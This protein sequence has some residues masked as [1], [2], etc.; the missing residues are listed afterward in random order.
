MAL[1]LRYYTQS[2]PMV[3]NNFNP[4]FGLSWVLPIE[5][6]PGPCTHTR[7]SFPGGLRLTHTPSCWPVDGDDRISYLVYSPICPGTFDSHTCNA[8]TGAT[9][10][11]SLRTVEAHMPNS[12]YS[13]ENLGFSHSFRKGWTV[14]GDVDIQQMWH[15]TRTENINSPTT[16]QPLGPR[17]FQQNIN[18]LQ[19]QATGRG[20]GNIV[21]LGVANQQYKY[22][23]FS[24][25]SVRQGFVDNTDG[26]PFTS[27]Q[28]TGSNVGEYAPRTGNALWSVFGGATEKLP[29]GLLLSENLNAQEGRRFNVTTGLDNNG[30]GNFNDRPYC[31]KLEWRSVR[32]RLQNTVP[33][34]PLMACC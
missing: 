6:P 10:L 12:F 19:W 2:K 15:L 25:S 23:Q 28:T 26:D 22:I 14:S 29:W 11:Q 3:H 32:L 13:I 33:I 5:T 34:G 24:A 4:R 16:L 17:P 18:I 9:P 7:V 20:Y 8:F 21:F 31:L 27:P 1:G 30:D